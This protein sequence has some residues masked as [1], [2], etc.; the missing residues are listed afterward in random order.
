ME[1]MG[2]SA[3]TTGNLILLLNVG[4]ISGAPCWGILSDRLFNTRKWVIIAGSIAIVLTII[5]LAIIP[6]GTPLSLVSLLFF[7]FGFFNATG[8]LMYPHIKELMPLEMS[9]TAMTGI[10]FFTMIGPAVFLQGLGILMQ[11]LYPEASRGPEAFNAAFMVCIISLLLVLV[12]Y[13]F[14]REKRLEGLD[15]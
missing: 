10:N 15:D 14:T 12:L 8:L 13:F 3:L 7:C 2:Y 11:T 6:L 5:I 9:G 1:V 4:M